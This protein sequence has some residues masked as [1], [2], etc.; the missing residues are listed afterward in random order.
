MMPDSIIILIEPHSSISISFPAHKYSSCIRKPFPLE[1]T[2]LDT[3]YV[4]DIGFLLFINLLKRFL[5]W[6]SIRVIGL[7]T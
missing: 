5:R 3:I 1:Y 7:S 6:L 2:N 4:I